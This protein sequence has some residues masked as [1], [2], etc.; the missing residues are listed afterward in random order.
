M[1]SAEIS[2]GIEK[3]G[4]KVTAVVEN[5]TAAGTKVPGLS[6]LYLSDQVDPASRTRCHETVL[7]DA[8]RPPCF[9]AAETS[10]LPK[11]Q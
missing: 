7:P 5:H 8:M 11:S 10:V 4:W 3:N 1:Y 2:R 9:S 6:I